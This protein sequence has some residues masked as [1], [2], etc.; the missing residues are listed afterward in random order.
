M[1]KLAREQIGVSH[2]SPGW[3]RFTP[4][5]VPEVLLQ[6]LFEERKLFAAWASAVALCIEGTV[7][8]AQARHGEEMK[9]L[10]QLQ[11]G[12][13]SYGLEVWFAEGSGSCSRTSSFHLGMGCFDFDTF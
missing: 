13:S 4:L 10:L 9:L 6:E 8:T 11:A 5:G 1:Y 3:T 7:S 2:F 12:S